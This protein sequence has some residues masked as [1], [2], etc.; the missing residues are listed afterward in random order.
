MMR[1]SKTGPK[2]RLTLTAGEWMRVLR[3]LAV[4]SDPKVF[5]DLA[6]A[7]RSERALEMAQQRPVYKDVVK[8][9]SDKPAFAR[10]V[11]ARKVAQ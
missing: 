11:R 1:R 5:R 6:D 10:W 7:R 4:S 3:G 2:I 8:A 9:L